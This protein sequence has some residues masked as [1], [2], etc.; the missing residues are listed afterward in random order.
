MK[1]PRAREP[2][3]YT[4]I[5]VLIASVLISIA[6]VAVFQAVSNGSRMS[7]KDFLTRRAYQRLEQ[8]L[9]DPRQS[10]KG[11]YYTEAVKDKTGN[12]V[13]GTHTLTD[14]SLVDVVLDDR[15]TPGD[16]S[17]DLV[18]I[19]ELEVIDLNLGMQL[20]GIAYPKP[21][22]QSVQAKKL[23]AR[24]I[25]YEDGVYDTASLETIVS[26]VGVN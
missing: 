18:G 14:T 2:T 11:L 19:A 3:G 1:N 6:V 24:M 10:Y 20:G 26:L 13:A 15:D 7:R 8:I 5:E 25:W 17:D 12:L 4:L 9:E 22:C 16:P 23:I 21:C